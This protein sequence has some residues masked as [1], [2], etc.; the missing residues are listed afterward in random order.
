MYYPIQIFVRIV[1]TLV[2]AWNPALLDSTSPEFV[3][4]SA[5][6]AD[7]VED[8]YADIQGEQTVNVLRYQ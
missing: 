7:A 6:I 2:E 4:L 8:V 3:S 1:L 5:K